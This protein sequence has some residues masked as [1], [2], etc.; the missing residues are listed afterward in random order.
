MPLKLNTF[1]DLFE[2]ITVQPA[3]TFW[4]NPSVHI[5]SFNYFSTHDNFG[6]TFQISITSLIHVLNAYTFHITL[7]LCLLI[8]VYGWGYEYS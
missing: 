8:V 4:L 2:I 7:V 3:S 6:E 1:I 5:T